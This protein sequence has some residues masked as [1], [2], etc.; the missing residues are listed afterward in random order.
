MSQYEFDWDYEEEFEPCPKCGDC[1]N[2]FWAGICGNPGGRKAYRTTVDAPR[3]R[4]KPRRA[5][6]LVPGAG[7]T[8]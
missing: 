2:W 1:G 4:S 6:A 7:A 3:T 8:K 5:L